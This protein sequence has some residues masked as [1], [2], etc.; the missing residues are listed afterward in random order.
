M[1]NKLSLFKIDTSKIPKEAKEVLKALKEKG[2]FAYLVGGCV[3][4]LLLNKTPKDWDVTTSAR[5]EEIQ[6]I[7][8]KTV[9]DNKYGTVKVIFDGLVIEVTPFRKEIGYSDKRHPDKVEFGVSLKE[10]LARRDF[11]INAIALDLEIKKDL[12]IANYQ[13]IDYFEGIKDLSEKLIRAVGEASQRFLED[14]LRL[15]RAIRF[16][17]QLNFEIEKNTFLA[18][19]KNASLIKEIA[20]E[21]IRDE[22]EKI[23]LSKAPKKGFFLLHQA[24]LLKYL[25]PELEKGL[26]VTQR[27]HH[28]WDVFWHLLNTLQAAADRNYS[29]EVR[30]AALLHD[31]AKPVCRREEKDEV[32][33]YGHQVVG[34]KMARKILK[35]LRFKNEIIEKVCLLIKHH[36]FVYEIGKVTESGVRRLLRRVGKE[37]IGDLLNLRIADRIGSGCKKAVPY[38]LRHLMYML[39]KVSLDPISVKML[40]VNGYD[41]MEILKIPPSRKVGLI[42]DA[43][44]CLVLD[45]PSLNKKE[46]LKE[47]IKELGKL[48]EKELLEYRKRLDY[49]KKLKDLELKSKYYVK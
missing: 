23:I 28:R 40:Q 39:E 44:L 9:Y 25:I 38:R 19:K 35:R 13:I 37:N 21:R 48:S 6:K 14:A 33:F 5:P 16:S 12:S 26:G 11:T 4:D 30:L 36:M 20:K 3:R 27:G 7:F 34:A 8:K 1:K 10:D 29:L 24:G 47:K 22:L 2:F 43:L 42:L 31:I 32:V 46:I 15:I 17:C 49:R 18:I 45:D 41:V